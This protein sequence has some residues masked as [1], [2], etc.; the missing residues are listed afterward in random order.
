[1]PLRSTRQA[2]LAF[3]QPLSWDTSKV[4][5]MSRMFA[6]RSARALTLTPSVGPSSCTPLAPPLPHALPTPGPHLAPHR[7]PLV[8]TRQ[9]AFA[10]NQPLSWDTSKVTNMFAM[11]TVR[12]ARALASQP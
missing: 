1:M 3:N 12:S 6:V 10:F 11:F 7:M 2:A 9:A 4:T 8:S 5:T